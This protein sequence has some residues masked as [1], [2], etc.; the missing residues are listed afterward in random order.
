MPWR[1]RPK[2]GWS[3]TYWT[4]QPPGRHAVQE[5]GAGPGT[6][7]SFI[8]YFRLPVRYGMTGGELAQLFKREKNI[9]AGC[10]W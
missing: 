10:T 4:G 1:P 8:G 6:C 9:G 7:D 2:R 5:A 3:S